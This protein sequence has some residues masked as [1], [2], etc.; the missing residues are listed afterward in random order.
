MPVTVT[1]VLV[2]RNVIQEVPSRDE[3]S[4]VLGVCGGL[5][6]AGLGSS[7]CNTC[8]VIPASVVKQRLYHSLWSD[9]GSRCLS[10][11]SSSDE[12]AQ[13]TDEVA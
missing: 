1:P 8:V 7:V 10:S 9:S 6:G 5:F 13:R 4:L 12:A 2:P 11:G 3:Y